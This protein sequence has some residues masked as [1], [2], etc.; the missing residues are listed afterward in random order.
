M[1]LGRVVYELRP[2]VS[3][4]LKLL[5]LFS[6]GPR[7]VVL[8]T[9]YCFATISKAWSQCVEQPQDWSATVAMLRY[10][11]VRDRATV[12]GVTAGSTQLLRDS[13]T[14]ARQF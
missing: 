14:W 12:C 7:P 1:V 10:V 8:Q 11:P 2:S 5:Q 6:H 3:P 9:R 4:N 13:Y